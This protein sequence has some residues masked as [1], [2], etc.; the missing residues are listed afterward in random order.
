MIKRLQLLDILRFFLALWVAIYHLCGGHGW[1]QYLK[2]PYGNLISEDKLG[3]FSSIVSLG[4]VAVPIFFVLSG[5][6][7]VLTSKNKSASEFIAY[8]FSRLLPGFI[9]SLVLTIVLFRY[10]FSNIVSIKFD[11]LISTLNGSW[12]SFRELPIVGSYWTLWAEARFYLL[13]VFVL[14]FYK[15]IKYEKKVF[16]FISFWLITEYFLVLENSIVSKVFISDY[17]MYFILGGLLALLSVTKEKFGILVLIFSSLVFS[18]YKL[19][20]WIFEWSPSN[21][22]L[23]R[24][25]VVLF[26]VG[27]VV[28]VISSKLDFKKP[29]F[30]GNIAVLGQSSYLIYLLQESLGMPL[31]SYLVLNGFQIRFAIL[32][33]LVL[34]VAISLTFSAKIEPKLIYIL[35]NKLL[36]NFKEM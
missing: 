19:R 30:I 28:I 3:N 21:P 35:R 11:N 17:A 2:Y 22:I 23:W 27:I 25:G 7:I 1:F 26:L 14:L 18:I 15:N 6:V 29:K 34:I 4:Y 33:S 8:R 5:Y 20:I 10:G 12:E 13:F 16:I 31:T 9:F 24:L 36:L 32:C